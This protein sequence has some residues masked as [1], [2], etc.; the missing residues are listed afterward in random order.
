ME[1]SDATI[2]EW[3]SL[4]TEDT[5]NLTIR[6]EK[7]DF[8]G[9]VI[10]LGDFR[11]LPSE[12]QQSDELKAEFQY[13]VQEIPP[14]LVNVEFSDEEGGQFENLIGYIYI[15]ILKDALETE[16]IVN[17]NGKTRKYDFSKPTAQRGVLS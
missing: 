16:R 10:Q 4:E 5:S 17:E 14:D 6:I 12:E 7:G 3:Y 9:V 11:L 8:A 15:D 13:N 1:W 2:K